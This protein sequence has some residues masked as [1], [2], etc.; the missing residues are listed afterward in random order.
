[1]I[2]LYFWT[3]FFVF[4]G[5]C[6]AACLGGVLSYLYFEE[7]EKKLLNFAHLIAEFICIDD[8]EWENTHLIFQEIACRKLVD[9]NIIKEYDGYYI[10]EIKEKMEEKMSFSK[11]RMFTLIELLVVI[12]IIAILAVW[13]CRKMA[14][15]KPSAYI[16]TVVVLYPIGKEIALSSRTRKPSPSR[17]MGG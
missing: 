7:K 9:L 6:F 5:L 15:G 8:E 11:I 4:L 14:V 10:Y 13:R 17:R 1:M 2:R 12:A 3:Y 16:Q